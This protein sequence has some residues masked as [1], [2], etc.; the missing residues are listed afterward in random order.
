MVQCFACI[1]MLPMF[2]VSIDAPHLLQRIVMPGRS[3]GWRKL[4]SRQSPEQLGSSLP[5]LWISC[6][7]VGGG[8]Q[9]ID[10]VAAETIMRRLFPTLPPLRFQG[11]MRVMCHEVL[12][13]IQ[14]CHPSRQARM[15]AGWLTSAAL[16]KR[17]ILMLSVPVDL[18]VSDSSRDVIV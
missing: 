17:Q 10:V 14:D 15:H 12:G 3:L 18:V 1:A 8:L 7:T 9:G 6:E 4:C 2:I 11:L 5:P 16:I 13:H